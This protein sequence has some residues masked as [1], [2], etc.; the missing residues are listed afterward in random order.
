VRIF[1][2]YILEQI[3]C[4]IALWTSLQREI[5]QFDGEQLFNRLSGLGDTLERGQGRSSAPLVLQDERFQL[6]HDLLITGEDLVT[7]EQYGELI[8]GTAELL[9][10]LNERFVVER[11]LDLEGLNFKEG[12]HRREPGEITLKNSS[13]RGTLFSVEKIDLEG[14]RCLRHP[15]KGSE[16]QYSDPEGGQKSPHENPFSNFRTLNRAYSS[17]RENT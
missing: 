3:T 2:P 7:D 11:I 4:P 14:E 13:A 15:M 9:F 16:K 12:V 8:P 10:Q 17:R 5:G 1:V 6:L